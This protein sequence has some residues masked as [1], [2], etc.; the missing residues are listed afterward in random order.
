M[1]NALFYRQRAEGTRHSFAP[2]RIA[3]IMIVVGLLGGDQRAA[4]VHGGRA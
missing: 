3:E 4:H 1:H 2:Y